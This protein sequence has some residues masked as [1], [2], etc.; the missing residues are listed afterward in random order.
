MANSFVEE[1]KWRGMMHDVMPGTD[2]H[3]AS[4]MQAAY[5]GIDPTADSLH[6]GHLVA[7]MMLRHFQLAGHKPFAL[8]GGATGMIGDPSGKSAERNLLDETTLRHNQEALK[9]QLSRFLDFESDAENTAILVNNYDW[10]KDFSFLDFIRD[11]GKHITVNYMMAKD[12]V[13]KRLGAESKEGM[14]FTEFTYQLVQ[15][16]DFLHLYQNHSCSLQMGGSDQWGNIV[17]G[18]EL[19]RRIGGGKGYALTCPLITKADGTKFGKTESGNVW[20]DPERTSPYKFYQYWLNTS[21]EDAEKYIKI[22]TFL[23]KEEIEKLVSEHKETPHLRVL[24]KR[25]AEETTVMVHSKEDLDNAVQASNILFGKST[26]EDLKKLDE[27]TFLDVFDGVPQAEI[28]R[29]DLEGGLDMIGALSAKTGFLGSNG[30]ARRELK[31][32]SISVNK[33]KVNE[34]YLITTDDLINDKFV[35]LQ[36]GKKNYFV[37]V[38]L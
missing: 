4:G 8:I 1:L 5:V 29:S 21:D 13:K 15:G 24:Q 27:K 34:D 36:R 38:I 33:A 12:S 16:Y 37:L 18:T 23:S 22:F 10:M 9:A 17:T 3:L 20:L 30:E 26:S 14:S 6:I 35:L 7:V 2:E 11:V 25:L 31:Q 19:I 28:S 32:N